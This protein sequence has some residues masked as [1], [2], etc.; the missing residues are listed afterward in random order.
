ML[1]INGGEKVKMVNAD[2]SLETCVSEGKSVD[3]TREKLSLNRWLSVFTFVF[4]MKEV[5]T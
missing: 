5:C 3:F 2:G 4:N 1:V